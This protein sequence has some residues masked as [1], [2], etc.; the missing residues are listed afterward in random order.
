MKKVPIFG[1]GI[2]GKSAVVTRERRLNVYFENRPDGDK[3][4]VVVYGTPGLMLKFALAALIRGIL[5]TQRQLYA[6]AA[7]NFYQLNS[8]GVPIFTGAINTT[9][10]LVAMASNPTQ[11]LLV[12]G[13][14]GYIYNPATKT[15][16]IVSSA[17]FPNGART[18]TFVGGYFVC[19]NPGTQ[20]FNVSNVFDG[21]TWNALAFASASQYSDNLVAVDSFISNLVLLCE[22][23]IE[24]W[25]NVGATPQPFA[26]ILS[27]TSEFGLAAI[28][29]RAHIDNSMC[30]LAN[31]P[32]GT[33]QVCRIQGYQVSVISTPDLDAVMA[34]F[35]TISDATALSYVADGHPM[36]QLTFPTANRSFLYDCASGIWSETQTGLTAGYAQRHIGNLSTY[37]AGVTLLTDY[38]TGN[39][40]TLSSSQYTDNGQTI[41]R[42]L[43]TRHASQDYN[44][45]TVDEVFLD[46]ET[47]VGLN[48]GQ[49]I[50]PQVSL[51]CS[52][53]NGRTWGPPLISYLGPI[54]NYLYRVIWRRFGSSRD[55]VFRIRMTDPVK[56]VVTG[57]AIVARERPQ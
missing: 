17:G 40:Y 53:D 55:F 23:H 29:S 47:G 13:S 38:Q 10:G 5:G 11:V 49:G 44:T 3:S 21:T 26:P 1:N 12:D 2:Y 35:G 56:F 14:Y 20:Q 22:R 41:L 16:A 57:G 6:V 51:E 7:G 18:A 36:Y 28:Y 42:E 8:L 34:G 33:P 27:A 32:Q 43:V 4:K 39:I 19:E 30:F 25:Q 37:Y 15:L 48:S 45:F 24:F 46:M 9:N 31:N 52:K 54:G 50:N